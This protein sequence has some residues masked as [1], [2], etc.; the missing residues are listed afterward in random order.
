MTT[1]TWAVIREI[2]LSGRYGLVK[3]KDGTIQLYETVQ[4]AESRREQLNDETINLEGLE[5]LASEESMVKLKRHFYKTFKEYQDK[6]SQ[7][8]ETK[9]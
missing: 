4:E 8:N 1:K 5:S 6:T 9:S 7:D 2:G 3:E